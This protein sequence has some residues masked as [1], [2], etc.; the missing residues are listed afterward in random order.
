MRIMAIERV[1]I[2]PDILR[3]A[4][5]RAGVSEEKAIEA[6]PLL[7]SWLP[8][9]KQP[10][11]NQLKRFAVKFYVPLVY[12][13]MDNR[14]EE[15]IPFPMFR[16]EAGQQDHFDLN[17]YDTVMNVQARQEWLE[18]YLLENEIETCAF[19]GSINTQVSIS[20]AVNKLRSILDLDPKWA[21][22][23]SSSDAALSYIGQRVEDA[24]VLLAYN[25]VV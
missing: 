15:V 23:M 13:F 24:G 16:G 11:L 1:N 14:P 9:K 5:Q 12:L 18:E 8:Q 4:I 6:F 21:F 2:Q 10:T 22:S 3:W 17:V 7:D 20:E 19:L 25:G